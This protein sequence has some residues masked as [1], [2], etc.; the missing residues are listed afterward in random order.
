MRALT[1]S[2]HF[3]FTFWTRVV[4]AFSLGVP[5]QMLCFCTATTALPRRQVVTISLVTG[6]GAILVKR[7]SKRS[8]PPA[9]KKHVLEKC[10]RSS[11]ILLCH[12]PILPDKISSNHVFTCTKNPASRIA[13]RVGLRGRTSAV[14]PVTAN[15]R[16]LRCSR[17]L[18]FV[19]ESANAEVSASYIELHKQRVSVVL[20]KPQ[21]QKLSKQQSTMQAGVNTASQ[22]V[23][24][25]FMSIAVSGKILSPTW[26]RHNFCLIGLVWQ[27]TPKQPTDRTSNGSVVEVVYEC[28]SL[29]TS[30]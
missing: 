3:V 8:I 24:Q 27:V 29:S 10:Y 18:D 6:S 9:Q 4:M 23:W 2:L 12:S 17:T 16:H 22:K 5:T 25:S 14:D 15:R 11:N 1:A 13:L 21:I 30:S 20:S 28:Q 19:G 7:W 26:N